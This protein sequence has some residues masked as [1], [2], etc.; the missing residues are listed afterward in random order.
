LTNLGRVISP[1]DPWRVPARNWRDPVEIL[2]VE[3]NEM[4][5]NSGLLKLNWLAT[6]VAVTL[7][8]VAAQSPF[9]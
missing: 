5:F 9:F 3:V 8:A 4:K 2:H 1:P 6:A 7:A